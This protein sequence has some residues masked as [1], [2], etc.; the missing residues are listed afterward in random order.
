M[1]LRCELR[2]LDRFETFSY[3]FGRITAAGGIARNMFTREAVDLIY[4]R[5]KGN[6]RT[7]NVISDNALI[8][9]LALQQRPVT[10]QTVFEVCEDFDIR[11][12][13]GS[14]P[15]LSSVGLKW[16]SLSATLPPAKPG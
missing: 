10:V 15:P 16:R 14:L 12:T 7:I 3:I 8:A 5:S 11:S 13:E 2:S 6:P 9:G 4:K 1:K